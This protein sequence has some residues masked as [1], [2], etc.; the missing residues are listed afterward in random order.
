MKKFVI[1][2]GA[3]LLLSSIAYGVLVFAWQNTGYKRFK[4]NINYR[5]GTYG[6][7]YTRVRE[8]PQFHDVD[9]LFLGSS[10]AYRGF[11]TRIFE[12]EGYRSFNLGSSSQTPIQ[13]KALLS[14]YL[15]VLN[16]KVVVY[17][18]YP[19]TFCGDG[20]EA[21]TDVI[22]NDVNDWS[23]V[24][25]L[26]DSR[27]AKVLNTW[28]YASIRD[29]FDLNGDFIE[30]LIKPESRDTYISGGY[31]EKEVY[32]YS[33]KSYLANHW[34]FNEKQVEEFESVLDMLEKKS[35]K[36]YLVFNPISSEFYKSYDNRQ[37]FD[38]WMS[39]YGSYYNFNETISLNDSLHFY[40]SNHMN[41]DGV[42]I[43]NQILVRLLR[44]D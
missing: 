29:L 13:T 26:W 8:I 14:R 10:H 6:N 34:S 33:K 4:G 40:D 21:S 15:A 38:Q 32:F 36:T 42:E 1:R 22:A 19:N 11:D 3:F 35:I 27:N 7:M 23:S 41:Q 31:V 5:I 25:M 20:V 37:E 43:Y 17:E 18:V 24:R 12:A 30:P 2:L 28:I 44:K 9:V 16:P 39:G